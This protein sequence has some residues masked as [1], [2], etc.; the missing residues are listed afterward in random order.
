MPPTLLARALCLEIG[1]KGIPAPPLRHEHARFLDV[2]DLC[3]E[4]EHAPD[5]LGIFIASS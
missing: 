2:M 3:D 1:A 4:A 5:L